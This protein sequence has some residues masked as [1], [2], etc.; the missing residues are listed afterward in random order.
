MN[1]ILHLVF[2][3]EALEAC[4][5]RAHE[6]DLVVLMVSPTERA[7]SPLLNPRVFFLDQNDFGGGEGR[8]S[9]RGGNRISYAGLVAETLSRPRIL[10]W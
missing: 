6:E 8:V 2:S 3:V 9:G 1:G 4:L 5:L 10:S 7:E